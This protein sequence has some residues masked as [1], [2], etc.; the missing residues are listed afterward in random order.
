MIRDGDDRSAPGNPVQIARRAFALNAQ[1][2]QKLLEELLAGGLENGIGPGDV[3]L[4]GQEKLF[5]NA[6]DRSFREKR[7]SGV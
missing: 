6:V 2:L 5:E 3:Q 4:F 7:A 1:A